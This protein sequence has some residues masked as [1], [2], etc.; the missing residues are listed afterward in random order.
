MTL[1]CAID[2]HSNNSVAVVLD[3]N[4]TVLYQ[5]RLPNELPAIERALLPF[6]DEL[7][8]VAVESTFNWYWL[9][10]GLQAAGYH[11]MLVNTH[12]VQQYKGLKH[13]NDVSD[14]RWLAHL[15]R[16]GILPTGYIYPYEQRTLRDLL[17]KRLFLNRERV[18][19]LLSA[20]CQIRRCAGLQVD[21][22]ELKR[23]SPQLLQVHQHPN[24]RFA[25]RCH[26]VMVQA[27]NEQIELIE[28]QVAKQTQDNPYLQSLLTVDGVGPILGQTIALET[29]DIDRFATVGQFASYCRCVNSQRLSNG[30]AKGRNNTRNGNKYLSWAF[31]EAAHS[32]IRHNKVAHRF[33]QRKRA[34]KNGALATKALAH[35]LARACYYVMRDGVAFAGTRLFA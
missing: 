5:E 6:R 10:D 29:G 17:R 1:F 12:A 34:Q 18:M 27:L 21:C 31:V 23:A 25:L 32:I 2:L 24:L 9:V 22:T 19:H 8:G 7:Y 11:V 3:E 16:L 35:K 30:K 33:Y 20:Q 4:D 26:L 28:R 15:M 14:A 13:T